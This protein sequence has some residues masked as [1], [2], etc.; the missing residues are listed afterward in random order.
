M[1]LFCPP[2]ALGLSVAGVIRDERKLYAVIVLLISGAI[3]LYCL[4][5][6]GFLRGL[7]C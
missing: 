4:F 1:L 2:L 7:F 5:S 6:M 3:T